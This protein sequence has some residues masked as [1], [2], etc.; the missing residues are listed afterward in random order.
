VLVYSYDAASRLTRLTR[1]VA[2]QS[3][4]VA[5]AFSYDNSSRLTGIA[6]SYSSGSGGSGGSEVSGG[7][8]PSR[9]ACWRRSRI[10]A[11]AG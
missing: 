9:R 5:T 11:W 1:Q 2:G 6:H 10:A 8:T 4:S 7:S 3:G